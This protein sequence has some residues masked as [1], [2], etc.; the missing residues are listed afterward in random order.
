MFFN[1]DNG[2]YRFKQFITPHLIGEKEV[3]HLATG[4]TTWP[5]DY[6]HDDDLE[7]SSQS[8]KKLYLMNG[9]VDSHGMIGVWVVHSWPWRWPLCAHGGVGECT[10]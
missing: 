3:N 8:V 7:V 5:F 9:R 6:I 1:A 10:G 2:K 4:P